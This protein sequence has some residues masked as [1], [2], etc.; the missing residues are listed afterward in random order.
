MYKKLQKPKPGKREGMKADPKEQNKLMAE[1]SKAENFAGIEE[2]FN[3]LYDS[4]VHPMWAVFAGKYIP[5]LTKED[6][7]DVFQE[8]W[9]KILEYRDKYDPGNSAYNWIFIIKKNLIIDRMRKKKPVT[10]DNNDD[11]DEESG[12]FFNDIPENGPLIEDRIISEETVKLIEN[13]INGIEDE[14]VR[15]IMKMRIFHRQT[16]EQISEE[17]EIPLTTVYKKV[18]RA[19]SILKPRIQKIINS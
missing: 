17:L 10:V 18:K 4:V 3:R 6:L 2:Q 16:F 7:R 5:P 13:E 19:L 11:E 1:I 15:K 14:T 8:A 9:I 12:R